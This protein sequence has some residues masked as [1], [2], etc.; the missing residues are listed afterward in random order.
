METFFKK[1][2]ILIR[3]QTKLILNNNKTFK[4][5]IIH[6]ILLIEFKNLFD[7]IILRVIYENN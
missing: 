6:S 4:S 7:L 3:N 1:I 2:A 5:K